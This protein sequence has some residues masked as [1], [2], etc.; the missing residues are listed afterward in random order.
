MQPRPYLAPACTCIMLLLSTGVYAQG[1]YPERPIRL[2]MPF[3]PGGANG[4]IGNE[5]VARA[6]P[7]GFT[8]MHKWPSCRRWSA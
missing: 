6:A 8:L 7:N 5:L 3:P 2:I 4:V 1:S